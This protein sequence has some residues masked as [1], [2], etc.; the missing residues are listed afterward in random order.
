L[1]RKET[2]GMH[3]HL[4]YPQQDANQQH[5]LISGGLDQVWVKAAP[6]QEIKVKELVTV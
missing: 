4:D 6:I 2:R 5:H 3:R 1:E